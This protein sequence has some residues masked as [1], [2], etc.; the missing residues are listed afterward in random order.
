MH[1]LPAAD[2]RVSERQCQRVT[3]SCAPVSVCE[4]VERAWMKNEGGGAGGSAGRRL[5]GWGGYVN[6]MDRSPVERRAAPIKG[7]RAAPYVL[8]VDVKR[9]P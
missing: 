7:R 6:A 9:R 3:L 2:V 8:V 1:A 5:A 4:S